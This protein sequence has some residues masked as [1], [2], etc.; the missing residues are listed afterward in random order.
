MPQQVTADRVSVATLNIRG[1]PLTGTRRAQRH[2]RI[3][4]AFEDSAA[5]VVCF[6]EVHTRYHLRTLARRPSTRCAVGDRPS[7]R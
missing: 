7:P 4:A 5:D 3:G 2:A 1:T 6:Q